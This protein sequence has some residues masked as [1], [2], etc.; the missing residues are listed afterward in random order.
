MCDTHL[1]KCTFVLWSKHN[2]TEETRYDCLLSLKANHLLMM[3]LIWE[4]FSSCCCFR[5]RSLSSRRFW[6]C[7]R[8]L[9]VCCSWLRSLCS[10]SSSL[11]CDI[12]SRSFREWISSSYSLT[13]KVNQILQIWLHQNIALEKY[14]CFWKWK[15]LHIKKY[16]ILLSYRRTWRIITTVPIKHYAVSLWGRW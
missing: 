15:C 1:N 6:Y 2:K 8:I 3:P 13:W 16:S 9:L 5:R 7:C 10:Y 11:R 4:S 12:F 14:S